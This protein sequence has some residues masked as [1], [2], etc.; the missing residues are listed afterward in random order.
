MKKKH[1][2]NISIF[3]HHVLCYVAVGINVGLFS[4][5]VLSCQFVHFASIFCVVKMMLN[6]SC[7][8]TF[9][10]TVFFHKKMNFFSQFSECK[11]FSFYSFTLFYKAECFKMLT[12]DF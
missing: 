3:C 1:Q 8:V 4:F 11:L 7:L 12:L 10:A 2:H 5:R 6:M 9:L